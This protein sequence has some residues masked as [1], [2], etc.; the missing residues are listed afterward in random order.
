MFDLDFFFPALI[1][2]YRLMLKSYKQ[3]YWTRHLAPFARPPNQPPT[4]VAIFVDT[5]EIMLPPPTLATSISDSFF[6]YLFFQ[7]LESIDGGS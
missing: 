5:T 4:S 7:S 1:C 6:S 2:A 3:T